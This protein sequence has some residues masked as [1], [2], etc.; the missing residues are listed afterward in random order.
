M[1]TALSYFI[2]VGFANAFG[3]FQQYYVAHLL[4][5]KTNFQIAWIGSFA[6]FMLFAFAAPAGFLGDK[7]GPT[8]S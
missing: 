2:T 4:V 8:V 6:T 5:P 3:V 7:F 1:G